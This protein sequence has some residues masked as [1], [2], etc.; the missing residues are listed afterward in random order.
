[1]NIGN[2]DWEFSLWHRV[3]YRINRLE[4]STR[5]LLLEY[6]VTIHPEAASFVIGDIFVSVNN[7]A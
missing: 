6:G 2:I 7:F 1:M 5:S 3:T 4:R